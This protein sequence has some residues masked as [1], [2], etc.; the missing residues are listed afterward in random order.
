M[1]KWRLLD[2]LVD[3]EWVVKCQIVVL[4]VYRLEIFSMVYEI[5][6][7]RYMYVNKI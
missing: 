5:F 3:D 4:K 2:V 6:L 1:R 7:V